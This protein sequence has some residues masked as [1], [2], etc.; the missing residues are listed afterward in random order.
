MEI[1]L[2][3][4]KFKVKAEGSSTHVEEKKN[5]LVGIEI[6]EGLNRSSGVLN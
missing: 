5:K 2:S 1:Y 4:A 3:Q 6:T